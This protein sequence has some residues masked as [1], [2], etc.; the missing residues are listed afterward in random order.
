MRKMGGVSLALPELSAFAISRAVFSRASG[1]W[2]R[3]VAIA[4]GSFLVEPDLIAAA[5]FFGWNMAYLPGIL[6]V[7]FV[8]AGAGRVGSCI[9][10][11]WNGLLF[12]SAPI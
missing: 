8:D 11:L 6:G 1:F 10:F 9:V 2:A 12:I 4:A 3:T 7:L 5:G